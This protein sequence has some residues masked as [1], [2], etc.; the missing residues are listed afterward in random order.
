MSV[1]L[2]R[3]G[4]FAYGKP[5]Y[6]IG[7]WL[8]VLAAVVLLLV[9]NPV[10]LSNEVRIDGT[11]S[12]KV[13]DGLATSLPEASGGQGMLLFTAPEGTRIGDEKVRS[14]LLAAVDAVYSHDHVIDVRK[15]LAREAAKG[16]EQPTAAGPGGGC[17]GRRGALL[18]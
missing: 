3:L 9:T 17:Q 6:V 16:R 18:R 8:A 7:A 11:P 12:Q 1:L 15:A 2:Y 4:R 13:I 10:K 14:A 5:W